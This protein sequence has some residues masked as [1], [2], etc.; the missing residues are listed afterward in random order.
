VIGLPGQTVEVEGDVLRVNR[1]VV[2]RKLIRQEGPSR[3]SRESIGTASFEIASGPE[4]APEISGSM[5][6]DLP[7]A[8]QVRLHLED[9]RC[10]A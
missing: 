3:I 2:A 1:R 7:E 4:L 10:A 9:A 8:R 5:R 6:V